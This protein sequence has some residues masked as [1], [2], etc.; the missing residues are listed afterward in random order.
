MRLTRRGGVTAVAAITR[1]SNRYCGNPYCGNSYCASVQARVRVRE[2]DVRVS[3][4]PRHYE[5]ETRARPHDKP[6]KAA[7]FGRGHG[8]AGRSGSRG[9]EPGPWAATP[10]SE[11]QPP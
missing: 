6:T 9:P 5:L 4:Q 7:P 1:F 2:P 10:R 8:M 11:R 3:V